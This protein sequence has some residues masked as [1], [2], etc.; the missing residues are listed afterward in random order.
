MKFVQIKIDGKEYKAYIAKTE[1]E[2]IK[3]LQDVEELDGDEGM[4]FIYDE[5]QELSFWMK[6]TTI[7]LDIVFISPEWIINSVHKGEPL[8]TELMTDE[9]SQ[10]V[11]E[12]NQNSGVKPGMEVEIDEMDDDFFEMEENKMYI[13]GSDGKPQM[14]LEG[15]ERIFS[16][17]NTKTLIN[18][19]RRAYMSKKESDYKRLGKKLFE[20]LKQQDER[21]A[22]YVETK[23]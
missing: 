6:D 10:F 5:P 13:I 2:K 14:E 3:G 7:P 1:E 22:E 17:P 20:Y 11:L 19:A 21:P 8:S 16:R 4:L 18:M 23:E 12:I 15:G 9:N